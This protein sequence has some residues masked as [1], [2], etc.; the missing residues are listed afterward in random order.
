MDKNELIIYSRTLPARSAV[1][2][3]FPE[4]L[5]P[6][7]AECLREMGIR[8]LYCHQAEMF[9]KVEEGDH[10]V[11]TTST[12][13]G[14][15]LS[16]LLPVIQ[17]ILENPQ[18]R[19]I[20]LY[21]TKA[22]A[23]DQY[24]AMKPLLDYFGEHR[25]KAGVYDGDTPTN[26]RGRLRKEANILLT[27]PEMLSGAFLPNHSR[28]GFDFIFSN[29]RYVVIDELHTYRG[30]FGSHMSNL[31]RR[32]GRVCSYYGSDPGFLCSSATIA[33]PVELAQEV[34]GRAFVRVEKDGSP[35]AQRTYTLVQPPR[36]ENKKGEYQ[37]QAQA[38]AVAADMIPQIM[39]E[40][41]SF[42]TFAKSRRN[43]EVILRET[44]DKLDAAGFLGHSD[45]NRVAGYRGGYTPKERRKIEEDMVSGKLCG[46]VST[47][48]LELGIDIGHVDTTILV[49]YPGTRASFWQQTGRAGRS[50]S[51]SNSYLILE[52]LPIDQYIGVNPGWL[53]ESG[54]EQAVVDKNNLLIQL[55]HIRAAAA[56]LPL[57]LDDIAVFPDL[58]EAIPVLM[59]VGELRNE[60]GRFAWSGN[61]FPAGDF[62]MRN[63]DRV[64]Y[65]LMDRDTH[66][67]ITEMDELQ[68]YREL[69]EGAIYMH[70]GAQYQVIKLDRETRTATAVPFTGD[71]Y[72][73][74]G[75]ETEVRIIREA[76]NREFL[77]TRAH[78]GD[79]NVNDT[80]YMYK[81]LQFHNHQN[82]GYEQLREQLSKDYD[83]EALW[84]R[85][86][87]QVVKVYRGL[88]Q[89]DSRGV[90]TR[91]NHFDGICHAIKH[92]AMLV[93]MT[94]PEDI[95]VTM[96][97]NVIGASTAAGG[98][99]Y[100]YLYDCFEGGL[101]Y[102]QKAYEHMEEILEAAIELTAGCSCKDGCAVC[103]GDYHLDRQVVLW[104]LR[105]LRE[106]LEPPASWKYVQYAERPTLE[107]KFQFKELSEKW[108]EFGLFMLGTGDRF[109]KF[110]NTIPKVMVE[111]ETLTLYTVNEFYRDWITQE[112]NLRYLTN[113]VRTY[114]DAPAGI[115][116]R[117][118]SD[119]S[120]DAARI[121]KTGQ[122]RD[123]LKKIHGTD[124]DSN[125]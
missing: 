60:H 80:I 71:Y 57:T 102:A 88:L 79:V 63:M 73:M 74:P 66:R 97:S 87:D 54:S 55:A 117:I 40:E 49:G 30:V 36:I 38:T 116:I 23:A 44:R 119:G 106:N 52:S 21:P 59:K 90:L 51:A 72:T 48:A 11:I 113:I 125:E 22:L 78:H 98:D 37:G 100:L 46:L 25:I 24:R 34:C 121:A 43:V 104:G 86:P 112:E 18:A 10:V 115:R 89:P 110:L 6:E 1:T 69:H 107:K 92:A 9:E 124:A 50:G 64:R 32:L 3:P 39:E 33:N 47:N 41:H 15:T 19:A 29:L 75:C 20:F 118:V 68:A 62:S 65:K 114:T 70:E 101:G 42:I 16:F 109:A 14:K 103:V 31:M 81:K 17:E 27:N 2:V 123:K 94:E 5:N 7:I 108:Q 84:I 122:I 120:G 85:I 45:A 105:S 35:A 61:A 26:E 4:G 95:D 67:E 12:A 91:N 77:M 99:V 82:L 53:F 83:T 111:E 58:G 96:S 56:E 13:S 28:Y 76:E 93:T 8:Q